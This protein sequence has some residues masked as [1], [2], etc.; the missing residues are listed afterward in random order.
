M[1]P[2]ILSGPERA[3]KG[4]KKAPSVL[5]QAIR[6][7]PLSLPSSSQARDEHVSGEEGEREMDKE[8][9]GGGGGSGGGGG[10]GGEGQID[11]AAAY[12]DK[13]YFESSSS[14]EDGEEEEGDQVSELR[15]CAS[16]SFSPLF[17]HFSLYHSFPSL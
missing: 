10:G 11:A 2:L 8:K 16:L 15:D 7:P 9:G 14:G 12:Y 5:R 6:N 17:S 1:C 13:V 3:V 4:R